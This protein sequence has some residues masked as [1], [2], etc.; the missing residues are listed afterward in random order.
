MVEGSILEMGE[1]AIVEVELAP[2]VE[3]LLGLYTGG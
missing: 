3:A 1:I 2:G